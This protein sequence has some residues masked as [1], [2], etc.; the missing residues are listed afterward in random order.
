MNNKKRLLL[1]GASGLLGSNL[2]FCFKDSF[3]ILGLYYSR[4]IQLKAIASAKVDLRSLDLIDEVI[5][6]FDPQIVIHCAAQANVDSC[7]CDPKQALEA[8][9]ISTANL[10]KSLVSSCAKLIHISTD[11]VYDGTKGF[12]AETDPLNPVNEYGRTKLYSEWEALKKEGA[13]VLRTNFFGW[14][15]APRKSLGQWLIDELKAKRSIQGFRDVYF[16][17]LYTFDLARLIVKMID[18]DLQGIYNCGSSNAIS[19]YEFLVQMAKKA[20]LD[21]TLISPV[22]VENFPF[23]AKRA[24]NLSLNVL[25]L[26]HDLGVDLPTI[27]ESMDHFM[28]DLD[29]NYPLSWQETA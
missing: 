3:D 25:K 1:T 22:Y 10:V 9:V 18:K 21:T 19:K 15:M 5:N 13:L 23:K 11:L 14:A 4:N 28:A 8:N 6:T 20:G 24:K 12:Y 2:A 27:E 29:K 26:A 17:S 7:E 16:S